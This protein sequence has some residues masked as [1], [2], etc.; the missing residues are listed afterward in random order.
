MP[1]RVR[2]TGHAALPPGEP[3]S[4]DTITSDRPDVRWAEVTAT[5]RTAVAAGRWMR[6]TV[7]ST[8]APLRV[9][10]YGGGDRR[11]SIVSWTPA[12]GFA[13]S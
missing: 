5:V 9:E 3:F 2:V 8:A 4:V 1:A 10:V 11:G 6:L 13:V 12:C 7:G